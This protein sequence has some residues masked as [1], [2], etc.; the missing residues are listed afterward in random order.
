MTLAEIKHIET[1]KVFRAT[2]TECGVGM[3][4]SS[5]FVFDRQVGDAGW[6][7]HCGPYSTRAAARDWILAVRET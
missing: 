5:W 7:Q 6:H 4:G 3:I 2:S 1:V